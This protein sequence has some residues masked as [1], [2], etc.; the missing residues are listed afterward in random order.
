KV[1]AALRADTFRLRIIDPYRRLFSHVIQ[2]I[3]NVRISCRMLHRHTDDIIRFVPSHSPSRTAL[4]ISGIT[5]NSLP[6]PIGTHSSTR[7]SLTEAQL[8]SPMTKYPSIRRPS[9]DKSAGT[10]YRITPT[11]RSA[12]C[13]SAS[14]R[15]YCK[16]M[17]PL[18]YM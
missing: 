6:V 14:E 8:D 13:R 5:L 17:T 4:P 11:A 1:V 9:G 7:P 10:A 16:F 2:D 3:R 18:L 15:A 12:A